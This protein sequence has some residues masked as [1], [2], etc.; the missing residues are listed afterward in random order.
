MGGQA[1]QTDQERFDYD[2]FWKA[3][4]RRFWR[5]LLKSAIPEL[6]IDANLEQEATPLDKELQDT[7]L[8][9]DNAEQ[10]SAKFVD[11]LLKVPLKSG[12]EQ[13]VLLH[14]EV[15]GR[16]GE[17]LSR[18]MMRYYCLLFAHYDKDP[19]ALSI[20]TA[21]RPKLETPGVYDFLQYGTHL[22]YSYNCLELLKLDDKTLLSSDNP[23]DL[24]L[25]AAKKALTR[26]N[27]EQQKLTYLLKLTRLLASKGWRRKDRSDLLVF[28]AR[29]INLKDKVLWEQYRKDVRE[30]KGESEMMSLW[31]EEMEQSRAEGRTEG[32]AEG[33]AEVA[34]R[35][36]AAQLPP[37]QI[38]EFTGL[39]SSEIDALRQ[40]EHACLP[41]S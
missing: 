1:I 26:S 19:V 22:R 32:R 17:D 8:K 5:E 6:Y 29:V 14:I 4:V 18:R 9:P 31:D 38:S 34:R 11:T 33:R 7:L 30:L 13:W 3:L 16:G 20:L 12:G 37:A 10:V 25:Y 23:F 15:Q 2:G 21:P 28:I 39:T 24:A 27:E 35:M 40:D 41:G 36:L